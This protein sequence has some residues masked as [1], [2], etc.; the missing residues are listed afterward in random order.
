MVVTVER[1]VPRASS[2]YFSGIGRFVA[3]S[4]IA[5]ALAITIGFFVFLNHLSTYETPDASVRAEG[6]IVLT[7]GRARLDPAVGL[8]RN[9]RGQ[10]LLISGVNTITSDETL[11][12][13]LALDPGIFDCCVDIDR[14][15]M[16]TI[17]NARSAQFWSDINGFSRILVVTNDY[18]MPRALL[19]ISRRMPDRII[20]AF[21]V[22]NH[23]DPDG[24]FSDILDRYRVLLSEYAKYVFALGREP[25][26][27]ATGVFRS[28][29]SSGW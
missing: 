8:L 28:G 26:A 14:A 29:M 11:R 4:A 16:N 9:N 25:F 2:A 12:N 27:G 20:E 19:E 3:L 6:I 10:K 22:T 13:A 24:G 7:G 18:H 23:H 1:A 21:P 15:A 5:V 17:G